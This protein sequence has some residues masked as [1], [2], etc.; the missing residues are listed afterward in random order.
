MNG[1]MHVVMFLCVVMAFIAWAIALLTA[2]SVVR[3]APPGQK[4]ASYF[5][6]GWWRFAALEQRL[7]PPVLPLITR[8][9]RAFF[10]FFGVILMLLLI[11][12]GNI[13]V[14]AR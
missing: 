10:V 7:G 13:A 8:Y 2:L 12:V 4:L 11:I 9:R 14:N 6:L 3:L 5:Q 1:L